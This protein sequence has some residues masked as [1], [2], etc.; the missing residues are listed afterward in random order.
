MANLY[1]KSLD[2][3]FF[4]QMIIYSCSIL[5]VIT[6][7]TD[8]YNFS[9]TNNG[10][11][12]FFEP[13]T[14]SLI[15]MGS[16]GSYPLISLASWW[17]LISAQY[18]HCG[19]F[20]LIF[21][22]IGVNNLAF[23][24]FKFYGFNKLIIIYTFTGI[25]GFLLTSIV[26]IISTYISL[27]SIFNGATIGAGASASIFGLLGALVSYGQESG[28]NSIK[29]MAWQYSLFGFVFGLLTPNIDNCGHL[30]GFLGGYFITQFKCLNYKFQD[31]NKLFCW[32]IFCILAVCLSIMASIIK[33]FFFIDWS[34][35]N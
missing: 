21:N 15:I 31:N 4:T 7:L 8:P 22:M 25:C 14:K 16:S 17:T 12:D 1:V 26:S 35:A 33:G 23:P 6:L 24:I 27:P 18:L 13:S 19:I 10:F 34:A 20:H 11:S 9:L 3:S 2:A 28:D 30:G 29:Q 32:A 5:F